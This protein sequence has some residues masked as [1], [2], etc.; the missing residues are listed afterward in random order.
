LLHD[1]LGVTPI[2]DDAVRIRGQGSAMRRADGEKRSVA[3]NAHVC[4][5]TAAH[6]DAYAALWMTR[7]SVGDIPHVLLV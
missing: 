6:R 2:T 3:R 5:N 1:I 7:M 4:D